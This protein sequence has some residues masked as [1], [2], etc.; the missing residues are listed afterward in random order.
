MV[1]M[2]L[3]MPVAKAATRAVTG[4]LQTLCSP[5][6]TDRLLYDLWLAEPLRDR[7]EISDG[8]HV[9][10]D[11]E[12]SESEYFSE[13]VIPIGRWRRPDSEELAALFGLSANHCPWSLGIGMGAITGTFREE[14]A[15]VKA[16]NLSS[17]SDA[18]QFMKSS[19]FKRL[20]KGFSTL[21]RDHSLY[22]DPPT[23]TLGISVRPPG[24]ATTSLHPTTGFK[25]GLH[26]D[27]WDRR[28]YRARDLCRNR[29]CVNIG[30]EDRFFLFC[31]VT[32]TTIV[33]IVAILLG[34]NETNW[35]YISSS[36][37][38]R[39]FF[40]LFPNYPVIRVRLAPGEFYIAP[41][42]NIIHD[43]TTMGKEK[44]DVALTALGYFRLE[45]QSR[46]RLR[47]ERV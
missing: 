19:D 12:A 17:Q 21:L 7:I 1:A 11:K 29:I 2:S 23:E 43:A 15:C 20:S 36:A 30:E 16:L 40:D 46:Y 6:L 35:S 18:D 33:M 25:V 38:I 44:P 27:G 34:L 9:I 32:V 45:D 4:N 5:I 28:G 41:P 8:I 26:L 39:H 3:G 13:S 22:A 24:L 14:V 37:L 42:E 31:N 47:T 10:E